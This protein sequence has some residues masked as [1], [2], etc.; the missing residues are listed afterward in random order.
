MA[1]EAP[2]FRKRKRA[3][4]EIAMYWVATAVSRDTKQFPLRTVR[5]HG[6]E[7]TARERCRILT[8]ELREWLAGTSDQGPAPR[9]DGTIGRLI[10]IYQVDEDSPY[11]ALR[12]NTCKSYDYNL[13]LLAKAV[14]SKSVAGLTRKD[15]SRWH[16]EFAK[17]AA[18]GGE[19]RIRRAHGVMTMLRLLLS[20]GVSMRFVGCRDAQ[21]VL[22]EIK[23]PRRGVAL[24]QSPLPKRRRSSIR[25][26][27]PTSGPSLSD[28]HSSSSSGCGRS[29]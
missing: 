27:R 15:F 20:F 29:T 13:R 26:S 16:R 9:F 11:R 4:G 8:S 1:S 10:E 12:P 5:L 18:D 2:G 19:P 14:A 24:N 21:E 3:N 7:E 17:P 28:R 22:N 23:F 6:D 25:R